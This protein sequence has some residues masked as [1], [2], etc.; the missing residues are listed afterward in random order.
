MI[1]EIYRTRREAEGET[2]GGYAVLTVDGGFLVCSWSEY[3]RRLEEEAES[4]FLQGFR[5]IDSDCEAIRELY[6]YTREEMTEI[7]DCLKNLSA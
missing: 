6:G 2:G 4:L 5:A 1:G 7:Y 3:Y